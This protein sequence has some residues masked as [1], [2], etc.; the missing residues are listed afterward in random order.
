MWL[1]EAELLRN[2]SDMVE[3]FDRDNGDEVALRV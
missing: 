3:A 1:A 2:A